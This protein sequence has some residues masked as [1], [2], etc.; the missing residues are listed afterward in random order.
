MEIERETNDEIVLKSL[1]G[2]LQTGIVS[3]KDA[4]YM[5]LNIN[6]DFEVQLLFRE[7]A[8]TECCKMLVEYRSKMKQGHPAIADFDYH[9]Q[10]IISLK[11]MDG[12]MGKEIRTARQ[13]ASDAEFEFLRLKSASQTNANAEKEISIGNDEILALYAEIEELKKR[14][15]ELIKLI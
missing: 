2:N 8:L 6:W 10:N 11:S 4:P 9:I 1:A 3:V 13:R 7:G 12:V 14:N 15:A 5:T